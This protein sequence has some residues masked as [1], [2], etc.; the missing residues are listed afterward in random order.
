MQVAETYTK[1]TKTI[2]PRKA[3]ANFH[4]LWVHFAKF[5]EQ[6]GVAGE[7]EADLPSARKIFEK[8]VAVPFK[9]VD[10][11]AEVWCEWAEMEVRNEW[12]VRGRGGVR[13]EL[14]RG[15]RNYDEAI[16]VMQRATQVPRKTGVSFHDEVSS[17][18]HRAS[19]LR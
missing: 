1:A 16:K 14:I 10:E 11:L 13:R 3:T 15:R 19:E 2:V 4:S 8:A 5:Y 7:A 17:S 9:K 12:V 18:C 6:G